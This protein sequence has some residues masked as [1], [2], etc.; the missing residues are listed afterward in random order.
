VLIPLLTPDVHGVN[1]SLFRTSLTLASAFGE[2]ELFGIQLECFLAPCRVPGEQRRLVVQAG[3]P[4]DPRAV[5]NDGTPGR[6]IYVARATNTLAAHVRVRDVTRETHNIGTEVPLVRE[7][8][9]RGLITLVNDPSV[10]STQYRSTL[11]IYSPIPTSVSVVIDFNTP[12]T[13]DL[14]GGT[15]IFEPAYAAFSSFPTQPWTTIRISAIT[16]PI[17]TP[18]P[19]PVWAFVS[20]TNNDTQM[21]TTVTPQP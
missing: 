12:I 18:L 19:V 2:T 3:A 10:A 8:E 16:P 6:F 21:I 15:T 13:V 11:R 14:R 4:V 7:S 5:I 1:G 17:T 9:F 20:L